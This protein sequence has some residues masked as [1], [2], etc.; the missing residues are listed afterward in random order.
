MSH[1]Q[2]AATSDEDLELQ[3]REAIRLSLQTGEPQ[4]WQTVERSKRRKGERLFSLSDD[5]ESESGAEEEP[6]AQSPPE[7][8]YHL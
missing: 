1:E 4:P 8:R 7:T 5:S 3:T 6:K 2:M